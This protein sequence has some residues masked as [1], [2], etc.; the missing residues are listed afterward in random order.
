MYNLIEEINICTHIYVTASPYIIIIIL[1]VISVS[2]CNGNVVLLLKKGKLQ[3]TH[4]HL[5]HLANL[6][7][8]YLFQYSIKLNFFAQI[9][10]FICIFN[11]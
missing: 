1:I 4:E 6:I 2:F 5:G 8:K 11:S 10:I 3:T 9:L 7:A